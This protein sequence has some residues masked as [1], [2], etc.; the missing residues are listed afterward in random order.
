MDI[1]SAL[2]SQYRAALKML[3][4]VIEKCPDGMWNDPAD[5]AAPF[6]RVA[7]H[8]LFYT[9]FYLQ[10]TQEAFRPWARHCEEAE[11]ISSVP[12]EPHR[13][14]KTCEPFT[15]NDL[16]EYCNE[17]LAMIDVGVDTLDLSAPQC[18]FPWYKMSV[19]EHQI[20]NIRHLQHHTAALASRL[21][22]EACI[23]IHWVGKG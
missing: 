14:P 20:V 5:H 10:Q 22:R 9:H 7:Y 12:W 2:K 8:T 19:L 15:R 13:P 17:C 4:E 11:F 6:W 18:G 16:L 23:G 1:R 21:R 3:H